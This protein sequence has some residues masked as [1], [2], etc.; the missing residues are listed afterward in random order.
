MPWILAALLLAGLVLPEQSAL[1][2]EAGSP[3]FDA[4][5]SGS[6]TAGAAEDEKPALEDLDLSLQ[7]VL[8]GLT[9]D[10]ETAAPAPA[11][12]PAQLAEGSADR[13]TW[14]VVPILPKRHG[15]EDMS[16]LQELTPLGVGIVRR[17]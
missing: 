2:G 8:E 12:P 5:Y 4:L 7:S 17:F 15:D 9:P 13:R 11:A 6:L 10:I 3:D 16:L 14:W 1:G